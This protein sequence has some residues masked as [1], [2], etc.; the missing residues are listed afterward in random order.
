MLA[1]LHKSWYVVYTKPRWEKKI[2]DLL[3]K[4]QIEYYCPFIET[5]KQWSDRKKVVKEPVFKSYVFVRVSEANKW[6]VK[7]IPGIINYVYRLGKPAMIHD[8]E[9]Q[10]IKDFLQGNRN[11]FYKQSPFKP[12][13]V[14]RVNSGV[15]L[16]L[17]G[18]VVA[19]KGKQLQIEISRLGLALLAIDHANVELIKIAG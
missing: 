2:V 15:F 4:A 5:V 12:G 18:R 10:L 14:I 7:D 3:Y 19:F 16:N 8:Y 17:E 11:F 6:K 9:I 1:D 13:D